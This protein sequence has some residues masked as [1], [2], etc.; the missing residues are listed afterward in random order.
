TA[1]EK[2]EIKPQALEWIFSHSANFTFHFSA[3]NLANGCRASNEFQ[4]AVLSQVQ[5][6][7]T[8]GLPN[9]AQQWSNALIQHFR[10]NSPLKIQEFTLQERGCLP[11]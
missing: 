2:V 6:Y 4:Q 9:R 10:K 1:F 8:H 11:K 7:L 5:H 3:D